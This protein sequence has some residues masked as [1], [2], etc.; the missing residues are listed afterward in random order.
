MLM[1]ATQLALLALLAC[2]QGRTE[3]PPLAL[4]F[5]LD[6]AMGHNRDLRQ[7]R[8]EVRQLE[9]ERIFV[10]ARFMPSLDLLAT[11]EADRT[12]LDSQTDDRLSSQ[13]R[14]SQRLFEFGPDAVQEVN[15]RE[16]LRRAV[17]DYEGEVYRVLAQVWERFYLILLQDRQIAIR[18]ESRRGFEE[19]FARQQALEAEK[20]ATEDDVLSAEL[21]VLR[22][23]QRINVLI[24]EQ[25]DNKMELLRLIGQPIGVDIQLQGDVEEVERFALDRENAVELAQR[26][27][28]QVALA[29]EQL[30]EQRRVV[31]E[32]AWA[33]SPDIGLEAGVENGRRQA[34]VE[35]DK[36][37]STWG[38]D[39]SSDF[40]L[41]EG[42]EPIAEE[43]ETRWSVQLEARIPLFEGGARIGREAR[44][45]ARLRQRQVSLED[46]RHRID[47][48]VRQAHLL[49]EEA[50]RQKEIQERSVVI[51]RRRLEI[52]Q[53]LKERG[54]VSDIFFEQQRDRFFDE[55]D[56]LFANQAN[57]IRRQANLRLLMGY[58]E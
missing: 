47:L 8:E 44:E 50:L 28:V 12:A 7:A 26:N 34:R 33:Y 51:A 19:I 55:Q 57:Y 58:F 3:E 9:G 15:L 32:Q 21:N 39:L 45:R 52:N 54:L 16:N 17:Y 20:L 53:K 48:Q 6:T 43:G 23:D 38:M 46:L 10:R 18:R 42:Q 37:N 13:L 22:E 56:Q 29:G 5:C 11:Y 40:R 49:M 31:R 25:F 27:S 24:R 30:D 41:D 36:E 2:V 4:V 1:R 35:V 14:F